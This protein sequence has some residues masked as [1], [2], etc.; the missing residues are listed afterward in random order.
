MRGSLYRTEEMMNSPSNPISRSNGL[1]VHEMPGEVLV[2][3]LDS[4]KAHCLNEAAAFV[5]KYCD[6][7][8]SIAEI[9]LEFESNGNGKVT[10]DFVW[11][12]LDQLAENDLLQ[13][14]RIPRFQ[15]RSRRQVLKSLGLAPMV[16]LP[17]IASLVAPQSVLGLVSCGGCISP[18]WCNRM[19]QCPSTTNCNANGI[20]APN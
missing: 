19:T 16:A 18:S 15:G 1:V 14:K 5:W 6:G 20:C 7:T 9:M 11:L 8:H 2:Y 4:N 12:A 3:D 17:V 13:D 10:E